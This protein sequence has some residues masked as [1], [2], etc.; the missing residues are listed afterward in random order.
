M[1]KTFSSLKCP[2]VST[3]VVCLLLA[4]ARQ[5]SAQK[6]DANLNGMS[7]VWEWL[8][9]SP[10]LNPAADSDGD[11]AT[12]ALECIA[13]TNPFDFNSSPRITSLSRTPTNF[14]VNI[15]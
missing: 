7:D 10:G 5:V 15:G 13:G 6:I 8:Y 14:T 2:L 3:A 1:C 9:S 4:G 11:G 12:N